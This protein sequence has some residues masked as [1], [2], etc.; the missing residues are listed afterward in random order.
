M[1]GQSNAVGYAV[2]SDAANV[3]IDD[4]STL[5]VYFLRAGLSNGSSVTPDNNYPWSGQQST[6]VVHA[7]EALS[8]VGATF[9]VNGIGCH[10]DVCTF[11]Q[12]GFHTNCSKN[13][14]AQGLLAPGRALLIVQAA[15]PG[16]GLQNPNGLGIPWGE[17]WPPSTHIYQNWAPDASCNPN[18]AGFQYVTGILTP[19]P[20]GVTMNLFTHAAMRVDYALSL[21]ATT[22]AV[23]NPSN[24]TA[25]NSN[26]NY[27]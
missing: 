7:S 3:Y 27:I 10:V 4:T 21:N 17:S 5:P 24:L 14:I 22:A 25:Q 18:V 12:N 19:R 26:N 16:S 13:Y 9:N 11:P 8:H 15:F 23:A 6:N 2:T 20:G 1:A